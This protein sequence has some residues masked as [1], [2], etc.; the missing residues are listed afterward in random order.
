MNA[1]KATGPDK[2]PPKIVK[3]SAN[4]I[5]SHLTNII[6]SDLLK[7]LFSGDAKTASI[8]LI[9]KKIENYRPVSILNCFS[10]IY[11]KFLLEAFKPFID[12]FLSEYIAAYREH[13]SSNHVLIRLIEN[14]KKTLD[15]KSFVGAVLMDLSKTFDCIP[16]DLLIAK[17]HAYGFSE[18]TVTFIYSY[19]KRRKQNVNNE[20]FYSDF[21]TLLLGVP[22]G[23][24]L[25]PILFN[26]FLNDLLATLKMSKLY[27]F[28]DNN[29][30]S[31][32]SKNMSN[33]IQTLEKNRKQHL[34]G[35]IKM[36]VNPD[37]CQAILL[38]KRNENNQS[39]LKI[40]N[41]TIKT[42]NCVKLLGINVDN[43]LNF[44]SYISDLCKKASMQLNALNC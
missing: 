28:A 38:E 20:N 27:N 21:L 19:L 44:D 29:T 25:D 11:E 39:C 34:N 8:R 6:H 33:L 35:L 37:K 26:L 2:I 43:K 18:K 14:W 1:K 3:L 30:I 40:N 7:D 22:K 32:A 5:N 36:I 16:H 15:G 42:T 24:I 13:Y 10:K 41:E 17:L 23:S 4:L 9:F 12:T 31:T